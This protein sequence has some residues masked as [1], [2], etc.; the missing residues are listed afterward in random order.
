MA[1]AQHFFQKSCLTFFMGRNYKPFIDGVAALICGGALARLHLSL[2]GFA[3][4]IGQGGFALPE[5]WVEAF[6][7]ML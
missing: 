1:A 7:R 2:E 6:G 4:L 5:I 3:G